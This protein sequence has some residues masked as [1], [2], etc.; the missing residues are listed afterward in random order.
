VVYGVPGIGKTSFAASA[1]DPIVIGTEDGSTRYGA[2]E[3]PVAKTID[4]V[5]DT[6]KD[7]LKTEQYKT[8]VIDALD[9]IEALC[10]ESVC[11][12]RKVKS[13]EDIGYG[14]GTVMSNERFAALVKIFEDLRT[15]GRNVIL[16]AHSHVKTVNDPTQPA[17]YDRHQLKLR[18]KN[19]AKVSEWA[20]AVL[21]ATYEMFVKTEGK[22]IKGKAYGDGKRVVYTE[23]RPA[24]DAKNRDGLPLCMGLSWQDYESALNR[25]GPEIAAGLRN[26]ALETIEL[27]RPKNEEL[28]NLMK[29][30][31][32]DAGDNVELLREILNRIMVRTEQ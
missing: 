3:T 13:I 27:Y 10:D 6:L 19:S 31:I 20:D 7:L 18:E 30:S 16:I 14:K 9:G 21:F 26:S 22:S 1:P 24:W 2:T 15:S 23:R 32:L 29:K 12:E 5:E 4:D 25:P 11:R 8:V 17:A 28:A